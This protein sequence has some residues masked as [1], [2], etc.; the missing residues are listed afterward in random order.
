MNK[1]KVSVLGA[2]TMEPGIA[3]TYA[4]HGCETDVYSRTQKTLYQAT[5]VIESIIQLL[6]VEEIADA[7]AARD[8]VSNLTYTDSLADAVEG[9]RYVAETILEKPEPKQ[10]LYA[11]LDSLLPEGV[12]IASNTSHL[13]A[14]N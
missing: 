10:E 12:I 6:V 9:A 5:C 14:L 1:N 13:N 8:A 4:L 2:G 3:I 7:A 11:Q